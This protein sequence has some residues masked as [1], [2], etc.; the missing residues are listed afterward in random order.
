M[1]F[2]AGK[3]PVDISK[4]TFATI[5]KLTGGKAEKA[6]TTLAFEIGG[7]A[8]F[9]VPV[10]TNAL[11]NSRHIKVEP[12]STGFRATISYGVNGVAGYAAYLHGDDSSSPLWKPKPVPSPGKLTGGYNSEATP[13]WIPKGVA[14]TD[15][16]KVL[17]EASKI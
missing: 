5:E 4:K 17:K 13:Q 1:P 12:T 16:M 11:V 15:I 7:N 10:D 6:L 9:Y 3:S 2:K 8:D 14:D